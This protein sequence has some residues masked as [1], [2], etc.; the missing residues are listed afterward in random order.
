MYVRRPVNASDP[1]FA[2]WADGDTEQAGPSRFYFSNRDG[3]RVW[4]LPYTMK[5]DWQ[6]PEEVGYTTTE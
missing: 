5:D 3:T 2:L 6:T 4:R 1:F